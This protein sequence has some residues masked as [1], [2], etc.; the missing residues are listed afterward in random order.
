[1][2]HRA[3]Q[4]HQSDNDLLTEM[5]AREQE[6]PMSLAWYRRKR[7]FGGGPPFIRVS[8]RIFYRRGELRRWISDRAAPGASAENFMARGPAGARN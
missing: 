2:T 6:L 7:V 8:N 3:N 5:Q 1:M 4:S